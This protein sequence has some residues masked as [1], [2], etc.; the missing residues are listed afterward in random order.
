M[1][2]EKMQPVLMGGMAAMIGMVAVASISKGYARPPVEYVMPDIEPPEPD[3]AVLCGF[4][5]DAASGVPLKDALVQEPVFG[6]TVKT[7]EDGVYE[8]RDLPA[9]GQYE[10]FFSEERGRYEA[11]TLQVSLENMEV[12]RLDVVLNPVFDPDKAI[13]GG[14]VTDAVTGE[15]LR[16]YNVTL[17]GYE[18][19]VHP[20]GHFQI[21]DIEPGTYTL[22]VEDYLSVP[23]HE[24][25]EA[26]IT[27]EPGDHKVV[28]VRLRTVPG[29]GFSLKLTNYPADLEMWKADATPDPWAYDP[30]MDSGWLAPDDTWVYPADPQ[31][32]LITITGIHLVNKILF[33]AERRGPILDGH[34]YEFDVG[35]RVLIDKGQF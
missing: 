15:P 24:S 1:E 29:A 32:A 6:R 27:L 33:Y 31:G 25:V 14:T 22:R 9:P 28:D 13:L 34:K 23:R 7:D 19:S 20:Y 26:E 16:A 3:T 35:A 11:V 4:V 8:M 5:I 30:I 2:I 18:T 10:F 21:A 17:N 12:K